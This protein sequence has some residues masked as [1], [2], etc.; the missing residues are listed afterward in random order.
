MLFLAGI[1]LLLGLAACE[2]ENNNATRWY[3]QKQVIIGAKVFSNQCATCHGDQAEGA[4]DNWKVRLEDGSY[5]AP[6]LNGSGH[7]WHH[8]LPL[9]L[10]VVQQGGAL[11][12]GKMPG[13]GNKLNEA[14][15]YAVIA[16][17]Q[18]LW[19]DETYQLWQEGNNATQ[20]IGGNSDD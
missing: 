6:P 14:E 12:D 10:Q 4:V 3:S 19:G 5:P 16:W 9:L 11:F 2:K 15:Q 8:S 20:I 13:F 1:L 7:A 18:S 17:F